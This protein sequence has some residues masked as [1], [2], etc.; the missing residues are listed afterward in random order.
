MDTQEFGTRT[1][2]QAY[3]AMGAYNVG[4]MGLVVYLCLYS[5]QLH[6]FWRFTDGSSISTS[7]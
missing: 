4:E 3:Y 7:L 6:I 2:K 5:L 1:G